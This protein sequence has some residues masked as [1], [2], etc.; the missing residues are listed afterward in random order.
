MFFAS[1][2]LREFSKLREKKR[3]IKWYLP[4]YKMKYSNE[5][6]P[7]IFKGFFLKL[8]FNIFLF[9]NGKFLR[10]CFS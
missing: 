5:D 2:Y 6:F 7:W 1:S 10:N 3:L 9:T 8:T 4:A